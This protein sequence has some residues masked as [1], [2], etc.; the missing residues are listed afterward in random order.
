MITEEEGVGVLL[1]MVK[2]TFG[3]SMTSV[4]N[5]DF[6]GSRTPALIPIQ[7]HRRSSDS[8]VG[9]LE[10]TVLARVS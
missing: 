3:L 5:P 2:K 4:T 7:G 9:V 8:E 1:A 10:R 6:I